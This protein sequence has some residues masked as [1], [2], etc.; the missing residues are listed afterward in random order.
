MTFVRYTQIFMSNFCIFSSSWMFPFM[1]VKKT[2]CFCPQELEAIK[3]R[4]REMEEEAEKLKELQNEVE[5]QMNLSPPPGMFSSVSDEPAPLHRDT[6]QHTEHIPRVFTMLE[7]IRWW[8][9][10]NAWSCLPFLLSCVT[11]VCAYL[12]WILSNDRHQLH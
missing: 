2:H 12:V 1:T 8:R 3:A 10:D 4:V 9:A 6:T 7:Q 5:K 11:S